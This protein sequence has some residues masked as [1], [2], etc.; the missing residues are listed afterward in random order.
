MNQHSISKPAFRRKTLAALLMPL[1][2]VA[3]GTASL[4]A[5]EPTVAE[6]A[7]AQAGGAQ[8]AHHANK[9]PVYSVINIAAEGGL[10][11]LNEKGQVAFS[12]FV[13]NNAGYFDGDRLHDLGTVDGEAAVVFGLNNRGV[14]IGNTAASRS[15]T[16]TVAGGYRILPAPM[17]GSARAVND[18]NQVA[19]AIYAPGVSARAARWDAN[20]TLR[21]LGTLPFSLSEA[22]TINNHGLTGGFADTPDRMYATLWDPVGR[23]LNLAPPGGNLAFTSLVNDRG[24]AAGYVSD[25]ASEYTPGFFRSAGGSLVLTGAQGRPPADLNDRGELVGITR[26]RATGDNFFGYLWTRSRGLALL[27]RPPGALYTGAVAINERTDIV[28]V[29]GGNEPRGRAILWRGLSAPID[30]NGTLYRRPPGLVLHGGVAINDA[31]AILA[32]SNAGLVLLRPGKAGTDAPVLGPVQALPDIVELGQE[33]RP[34]LGFID[35]SRTQ[36]HSAVA[37]W[38][39]GCVSP[40]PLVRQSAGGGEVRLQHRFCAPGFVTLTLRVTDSGGRTTETRRQV[41]VNNPAAATVSGRGTLSGAGGQALHFAFWSPLGSTLQSDNDR[42]ER[43][44]P[45]VLL[46][47]PFTFESDRVSSAVRNGQQIRIEGTGRF[48]GR[49]GYRFLVD[50]I[51]GKGNNPS[52]ADR[53]RVRISHLDQ[54]GKEVLDYDSAPAAK[55]GPV[56]AVVSEGAIALSN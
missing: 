42:R 16:W 11:F 9:R 56:A 43:G 17:G 30:L 29:A 31:G 24:D 35:N 45:A 10:S 23:Q 27:P 12:S 33:A 41:L 18:R 26:T 20:G 34:T 54:T 51:D 36:T 49:T 46:Q 38:S 25:V 53:M 40:H 22:R 19:G 50:A 21:L 44:R 3:G 48:D 1:L 15:F 39:D 55:A 52:D 32:D 47:G 37:E 6:A 5:A 4:S 2:A 8:A 28:G 14:A 13:Y 7:H